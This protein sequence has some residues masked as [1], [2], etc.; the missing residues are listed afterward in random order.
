MVWCCTSHSRI[1][2]SD[3]D[4]T[5]SGKGLQIGGLYTHAQYLHGL[6]GVLIPSCLTC[7]DTGPRFLRSRTK[8]HSNLV[9]FY[10]KQVALRHMICR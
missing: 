9:A 7:C 1:F 8:D 6:D 4:V 3:G 5:I 2:H 10:D